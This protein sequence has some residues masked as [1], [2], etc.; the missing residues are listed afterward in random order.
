[1]WKAGSLTTY[2]C[3]RSP[4][5]EGLRLREDRP[6]SSRGLLVAPRAR[7]VERRSRP[8]STKPGRVCLPAAGRTRGA[9][10]ASEP[11]ALRRAPSSAGPP[12]IPGPS[13]DPNGSR[14]A[15]AE[16]SSSH[17]GNLDFPWLRQGGKSRA[18]DDETRRAR[19]LPPSHRRR[20]GAVKVP[21][22]SEDHAGRR[23]PTKERR[24]WARRDSN[25]H[26]LSST[27]S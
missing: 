24:V 19:S 25:P 21:R 5:S 20:S 15:R 16:T 4:D 26:A 10:G 3:P 2:S 9:P 6:G 8:A 17:S 27:S 23:R 11:R 12:Q 1:M 22:P 7:D 14:V 13:E 18:A